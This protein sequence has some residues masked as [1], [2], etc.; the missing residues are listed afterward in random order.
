MGY[1]NYKDELYHHGVL[2]MRWGVRRY[3]PYGKGGYTPKNVHGRTKHVGGKNYEYKKR[4]IEI[5]RDKDFDSLKDYKSKLSKKNK[6]TL[7]K[8][9]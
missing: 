5:I 1:F 9:K 7:R 2:G 3:Q 6:R 4:N 8:I